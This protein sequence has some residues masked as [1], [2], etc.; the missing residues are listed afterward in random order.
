MKHRFFLVAAALCAAVFSWSMTGCGGIDASPASERPESFSADGVISKEQ[1]AGLL[2]EQI[3]DNIESSEFNVLVNVTDGDGKPL[4][5]VRLEIEFSRPDMKYPL[6]SKKK[7]SKTEA[8]TIDSE[9]RIQGKGWTNLNLV[10]RKDG[11]F[12]ES[13]RFQID[14][15][16]SDP[17]PVTLGENLR[18]QMF[19]KTPSAEMLNGIRADLK[20]DFK[21][22]TRTI[23]DLSA[24]RKTGTA[25]RKER[26]EEEKDKDRLKKL[27]QATAGLK[28]KPEAAK[29]I[30][31]DFRRDERG[32]IVYGDPLALYR[33]IPCPSAF[34]IRFRSDDPDDGMI[35]I[36][37]LDPDVTHD[38]MKK[39]HTA[40][41]E[42]GYD[43][44]EI[45]I[46]LGEADATGHYPFESKRIYIFLKCGNHFGKAEIEQISLSL[47][48]RDQKIEGVS[49][50]L[51][52]LLNQKEGDRNL[53]LGY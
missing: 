41:P 12:I 10:F 44:K 43:Q 15:M 21:G 24:F 36:D 23:C 51:E 8:K 31:L 7:E 38:R 20:Y 45:V 13:R 53:S 19:Q 42:T 6:F 18:V 27:K 30:E 26:S 49:T 50:R 1:A 9:L 33:T 16:R 39:I 47:N 46:E 5:G 2:Q 34:I 25:P 29:Y 14:F 3:Q 40:A 11:Y 4:N 48:R 35:L 28:T 22:E 17:S 52:I 32:E 37:E